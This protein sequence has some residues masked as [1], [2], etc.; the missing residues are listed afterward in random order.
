MVVGSVI[1]VALALIVITIARVVGVGA[2]V[3]EKIVDAVACFAGTERSHSVV[4]CHYHRRRLGRCEIGCR[5]I[6]LLALCVRGQ[7]QSKREVFTVDIS[8]KIA[9]NQTFSDDGHKKAKDGGA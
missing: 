2:R 6:S 9:K 5:V 1:A 4:I 7:R 8:Y 3:Q